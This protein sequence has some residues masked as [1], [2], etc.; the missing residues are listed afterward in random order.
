MTNLA[1]HLD[2]ALSYQSAIARG[3]IVRL[4]RPPKAAM[5]KHDFQ[6]VFKRCEQLVWLFV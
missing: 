1:V 2:Q 5:K 6:E 3:E 4:F